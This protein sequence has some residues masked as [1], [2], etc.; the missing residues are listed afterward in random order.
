MKTR[1]SLTG[2]FVVIAAAVLYFMV[3]SPGS[4]DATKSKSGSRRIQ[5]TVTYEANK[6][7]KVIGFF[8][9][10]AGRVP[11]EDVD[12][13]W[14]SKT[15]WVEKG[16]HVELI[17]NSANHQQGK[18]SG[19]IKNRT[20]GYTIDHCENFHGRDSTGIGGILCTGVVD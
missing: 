17:A 12:G 20:T 18:V 19:W 11:F 1:S 7:G 9:Y 13:S 8:D 5:F 16:T 4:G 14:N 6:T 2:V 10:G 3:T 15:Y